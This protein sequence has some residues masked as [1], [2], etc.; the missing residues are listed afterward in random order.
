M[1]I[2]IRHRYEFILV[3]AGIVFVIVSLLSREEVPQKVN[4]IRK[5]PFSLETSAKRPTFTSQES[6]RLPQRIPLAELR[7][8]QD[9]N[10]TILSLS[11]E[12]IEGF[13]LY[14]SD[15][16]NSQ[17]F[18]CPDDDSNNNN[19]DGGGRKEV[20]LWGLGKSVKEF[21]LEFRWIRGV[22]TV[23]GGHLIVKRGKS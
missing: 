7:L 4:V 22:E 6:K 14:L 5:L 12:C 13:S 21:P 19:N 18:N 3:C 11:T 16:A 1:N 8:K 17:I 20:E 10:E 23:A 15:G 9:G 2:V